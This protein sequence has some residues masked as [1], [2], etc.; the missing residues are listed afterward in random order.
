MATTPW[1]QATGS[2]AGTTWTTMV[3]SHRWV[4]ALTV[5]EE[6]HALECVCVY[7]QLAGFIS[8]CVC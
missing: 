1:T 6:Y 7:L 4:D 8:V 2:T 3:L 5:D